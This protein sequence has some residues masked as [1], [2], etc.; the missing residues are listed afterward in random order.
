MVV[1]CVFI[2]GTQSM[3]LFAAKKIVV[4]ANQH[5]KHV[6]LIESGTKETKWS[7]SDF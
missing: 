4:G 1:Q 5:R 7:V 6:N 3:E 2:I